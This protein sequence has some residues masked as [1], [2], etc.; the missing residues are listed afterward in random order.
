MYLYDLPPNRKNVP[1]LIKDPVELI[2]DVRTLVE[3]HCK[4][5]PELSITGQPVLRPELNRSDNYVLSSRLQQDLTRIS[6]DASLNHSIEMANNS[7]D[8]ESSNS[9]KQDFALP[10]NVTNKNGSKHSHKKT[11]SIASPIVTSTSNGQEKIANNSNG[12]TNLSNNPPRRRRRRCKNCVPCNSSEC[13]HCNYCLDMV[14][15][16]YYCYINIQCDI[17]LSTIYRSLI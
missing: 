6:E 2:K 14:R 9:A 11:N 3:R 10:Q 7:D 13:G 16:C 12:G 17:F 15:Q 8:L 4:D 1:E 5:S